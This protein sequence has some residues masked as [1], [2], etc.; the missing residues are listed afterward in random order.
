[1]PSRDFALDPATRL[2]SVESLIVIAIAGFVGLLT[3]LAS[4]WWLRSRP[5]LR[6]WN[7]P[8]LVVTVGSIAILL[9]GLGPPFV[10]WALLGFP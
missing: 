8:A 2:P 6:P 1:V 5:G 9:F 7:R 3:G 10:L 4:L